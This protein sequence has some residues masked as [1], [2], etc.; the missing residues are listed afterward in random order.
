MLTAFKGF[1]L[2]EAMVRDGNPNSVSDAG[3]GALAM[4]ACIEG[5]WLNVKINSGNLKDHPEVIEILQNGAELVQ[6]SAHLRDEII[7]QV[8]NTITH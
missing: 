8:N 3:V 5:A 4:Q 6:K 2:A 7:K 1:D